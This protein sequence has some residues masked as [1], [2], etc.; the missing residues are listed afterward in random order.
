MRFAAFARDANEACIFR[1][2]LTVR[3]RMQA[4]EV[5]LLATLADAL[6]DGSFSL[7]G[8]V[9]GPRSPMRPCICSA[10]SQRNILQDLLQRPKVSSHVGVSL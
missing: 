10:F 1:P 8:V 5:Q 9:H 2:G 3:R 4:D 6:G 7:C